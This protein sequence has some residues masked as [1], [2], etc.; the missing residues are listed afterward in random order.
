[1]PQSLRFK[2][3]LLAACA[4]PAMLLGDT[5][6]GA[7]LALQSAGNAVHICGVSVLARDGEEI[8]SLT[9]QQWVGYLSVRF[10][11]GSFPAGDAGDSP[12]F[13]ALR[14]RC[15]SA[16]RDWA[17]NEP[18]EDEPSYS[19]VLGRDDSAWHTL[20]PV[21]G[22]LARE[23]P[24]DGRTLYFVLERTRIPQRPIHISKAALCGPETHEYGEYGPWMR[25][26]LLP[27]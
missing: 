3:Q 19:L 9:P 18:H 16:E 11:L 5:A 8:P 26:Y 2:R 12:T 27:D 17:D 25:R 1:M 4:A 21:T 22:R 10:E 15:W 24:R 13:G 14:L 6:H 20:D 7:M 23:L